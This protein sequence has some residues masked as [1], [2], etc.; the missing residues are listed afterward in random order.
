MA[1][2]RTANNS[3][4]TRAP[5]RRGKRLGRAF[6]RRP[7]TDLAR[8]LIGKVLVHRVDGCTY[9]ARIVETEAYVGP[10]DLACH[11]SKGR[12]KRTEIMFG[13]AGH[14][15]IYLIYGM[16]PMLNIVSGEPGV[17]EA[18]L[19]R[20]AEPLDELEANLSGPGKLCREMR[21]TLADNTLDLTLSDKLFLI[22]DAQPLAPR[23]ATSKRI[24][25]DYAGEWKD[26][27][28]RFYDPDSKSISKAR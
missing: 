27:L 8:A 3:S 11:A 18:V 1:A 26:A 13:R 14:A 22:D 7:A 12:T 2:S 5:R 19:I 6:Y 25:V 28:L 24:G 16:Y 17:A 4:T 9:R 23:I 10:H 20:A 15:Y 21:I